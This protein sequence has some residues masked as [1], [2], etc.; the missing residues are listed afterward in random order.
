MQLEQAENRLKEQR[1]AANRLQLEND[2]I[3]EK[4]GTL[5]DYGSNLGQT[6][7]EQGYERDNSRGEKRS[8]IE[9]TPDVVAEVIVIDNASADG[10]AE[11]GT[12]YVG[13]TGTLTFPA[14]TTVLSQ[15]VSV[16]VTGGPPLDAGSVTSSRSLGKF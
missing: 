15:T 3:K 10:S 9:Q 2:Q 8:I 6:M 12:D 1:S 11:A 14:G 4:L 16:A 5:Y 7:S 13:S